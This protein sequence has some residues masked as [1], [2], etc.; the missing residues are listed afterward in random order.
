MINAPI[1]F[2]AT[3]SAATRLLTGITSLLKPRF[4]L[5]NIVIQ[6]TTVLAHEYAN[7]VRSRVQITRVPTCFREMKKTHRVL[8]ISVIPVAT[9]HVIRR[10]MFCT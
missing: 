1:S 7:H 2:A 3:S 5:N 6:R 4:R 9:L 10:H 8:T